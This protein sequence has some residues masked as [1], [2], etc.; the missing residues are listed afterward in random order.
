MEQQTLTNGFGTSHF[1]DS[2]DT[3]TADNQ[4]ELQNS[5]H[6]PVTA[7]RVQITEEIGPRSSLTQHRGGNFGYQTTKEAN[8]GQVQ[9]P[10]KFKEDPLYMTDAWANIASQSRVKD[11]DQQ[12]IEIDSASF[13]GQYQGTADTPDQ[14]SI[15][16]AF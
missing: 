14:R 1:G 4:I 2:I 3:A 8:F 15:A 6:V 10:R 9:K 7:D 11:K 13:G 16:N 12:S 5:T